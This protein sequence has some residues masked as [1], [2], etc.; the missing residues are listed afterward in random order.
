MRALLRT[1]LLVI[2]VVVVALFAFG[3]W[4]G[5]TLHRVTRQPVGTTG[6]TGTIDTSKARERGA[7]IGEQ[8]AIAAARVH[9]SVA[10]AA[11]TAKIKA[12]MALDD[13]IQARRIDVSTSGSTVTLTGTV[14]SQDEHDRAIRL[15]RETAGVT[16]VVDRL[17]VQ[18]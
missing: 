1:L 6:T 17:D 2:L 10:E 14:R 18:R 11:V 12:K 15:A 9:E 5:A 13:D 7:E 16:N 8:T 4:T 3:W